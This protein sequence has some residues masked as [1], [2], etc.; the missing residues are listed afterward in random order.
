M[1][2][3]HILSSFGM[4]GQERMVVDLAAQQIRH[5]HSVCGISL[6]RGKEGPHA[7]SLREAGARVWRIAKTPGFDPKLALRISELLIREQIELVHTHNPQP[8]IYGA[9][10]ARLARARAVH[11]KHGANPD[12]VRRRLLRR[13]AGRFVDAYVA[14]SEATALIARAERECAP[15]KLH[16]IANGIDL[17]RFA[18]TKTRRSELRRELGIAPDAWVMGTVGR[19]APE[20]DQCN[21]IRAALPLLRRGCHLL[22]AGGG[23]EREALVDLCTRLS[24]SHRV[25]LLGQ[26]DDIPDILGALDVFVLSSRTEGLPLVIPEAM[27]SGLPV[28]STAVGGIASVVSHDK[29]GLLTPPGDIEQLMRALARVSQDRDWARALGSSARKVAIAHYSSER[30]MRD[31]SRLYEDV[32][33]GSR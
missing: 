9:P 1:R 20:K 21:M 19:L 15:D 23:P 30:M 29:T 10:A 4:G 2:V 33:G 31:Y 8:L 25:H 6:A 16:V 27:A 22:I 32:L 26:R 12:T 14:V 7:S 3:A 13:A 18:S 28:V 17:T 24:C 11:T 5:G